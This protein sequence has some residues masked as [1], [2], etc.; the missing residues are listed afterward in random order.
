MYLRGHG[1]LVLNAATI[2]DNTADTD[3]DGTF[4]DGGGI[5]GDHLVLKNSIVA[6]NFDLGATNPGPDCAGFASMSTPWS[7]SA[8]VVTKPPPTSGPPTR[9]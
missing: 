3:A 2:T 4:P 1:D 8:P 6:G 7:A 5:S 9:C